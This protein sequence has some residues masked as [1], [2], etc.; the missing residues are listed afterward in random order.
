MMGRMGVGS[1][2]PEARRTEAQTGTAIAG[3][4]VLLVLLAVALTRMIDGRAA[5][6][7]TESPTYRTASARDDPTS[8]KKCC[9]TS[10]ES[11]RT[12]EITRP[13]PVTARIIDPETGEEVVVRLPPGS[14]VIDGEVVRI[15]SSGTT[16]SGGTATTGTGGT[17]TTGTGGTATTGTGTGTTGTTSPGTSPTGNTTTSTSPPTT[18]ATT[19]TTEATTTTETTTTTTESPPTTADPVPPPP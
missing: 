16:G 13:A 6:D 10:P 9:R 4:V 12:G 19:T 8:S 2:G 5:I 7:L 3:A 1:G 14:T 15:G 17:A 11:T 18:Q